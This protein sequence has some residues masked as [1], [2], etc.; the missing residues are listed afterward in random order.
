MS[1]THLEFNNSP[2]AFLITFRTYGSWLHGDQRGSV[3]RFHNRYGTPRLGPNP[4][5]ESYERSLLK[6][7]P[8]LLTQFQRKVVREAIWEVCNEKRWSLW[9]INARTNHVHTVVSADVNSKQ[10]RATLK[11]RATKRMRERGCWPHEH[12]PWADRGSRR[13]L[14]THQ[15]VVNA[16]AYVQYDQGQ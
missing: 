16:T 12:S 10:V 11:A 15:E 9:A 3:D 4:L 5:R 13:N 1:P 7:P 6:G 14:W 2:L 8:V